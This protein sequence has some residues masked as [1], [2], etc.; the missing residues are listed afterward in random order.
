MYLQFVQLEF[1]LQVIGNQRASKLSHAS[2]RGRCPLKTQRVQGTR[3][4]SVAAAAACARRVVAVVGCAISLLVVGQLKVALV[5]L[6][7]VSE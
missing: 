4:G 6:T 3:I 1:V 7:A 2:V 5:Q